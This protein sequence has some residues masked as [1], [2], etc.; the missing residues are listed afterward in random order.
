MSRMPLTSFHG[1]WYSRA[2]HVL[3]WRVL[4]A[5]HS[6]PSMACA[7]RVLLTSFHIR[8][9][10]RLLLTSNSRPSTHALPYPV[11]VPC[12]T[13][14]LPCRPVVANAHRGVTPSNSQHPPMASTHKRGPTHNNGLET[15]LA[16][17]ARQW[18]PFDH[19]V[20]RVKCP[21]V[22]RC[23]HVSA[24]GGT[25]LCG[26]EAAARVYAALRPCLL[27]SH[28]EAPSPFCSSAP[29][30]PPLSSLSLSLSL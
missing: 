4:L 20:S 14:G 17:A 16:G 12:V 15:Q 26:S 23:C 1:V 11:F 21:S 5:C 22:N 27:H 30:F 8:R 28:A 6:R 2:T 3:P 18:C 19:V 9:A 7:T 13:H 25:C 29:T 24:H 10:S